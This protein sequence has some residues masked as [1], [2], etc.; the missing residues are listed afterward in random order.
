MKCFY[1][2]ND[3]PWLKIGPFKIEENALDPYHV[4]ILELLY[5]HEC[6]NITEFLGPMLNFPP[7]KINSVKFKIMKSSPLLAR[8]ML[9]FRILGIFTVENIARLGVF[10]FQTSDNIQFCTVLFSVA[11]YYLKFET[12]KHPTYLYFQQGKAPPSRKA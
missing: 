10:M 8:T 1:G 4:T 11:D 7:G 6:N 5:E 2:H 12:S 9:W 3:S